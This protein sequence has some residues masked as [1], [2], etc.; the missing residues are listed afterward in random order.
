M[1]KTHNLSSHDHP[2]EIQFVAVPLA[3][4]RTTR[5]IAT[6]YSL[7][8]GVNSVLM[9][10]ACVFSLLCCIVCQN[11]FFMGVIRVIHSVRKVE[12]LC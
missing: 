4:V 1:R 2:W 12:G 11:S 3:P 9:C 6:W 5:V 10:V 8:H 7:E